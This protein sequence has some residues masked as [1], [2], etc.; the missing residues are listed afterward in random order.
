MKMGLFALVL[1]FCVR[2]AVAQERIPDE[3]A[4][5]IAKALVEASAK[6]KGPIAV[7]GDADKPYAKRK[8][9]HG[10]MVLPAKKLTSELIDKAGG[11]VVPIALLW[12]HN[13]APMVDDKL[14]PAK[15]MNQVSFTHNDKEVTVSL[16]YLGVRKGKEKTSLVVLGTD[17]KPLLSI[18]LDKIDEK[19]ELPIEFLVSIEPDDTA[20]ITLTILGKHK[21]KLMVGVPKE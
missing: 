16:C 20:S 8:D 19:Q 15:S 2:G 5:P 14:V 9:D 11:D 7:D 4:K 18:P 21:A 13:L 1:V 10:A 3:Q 6:V 12:F 17:K